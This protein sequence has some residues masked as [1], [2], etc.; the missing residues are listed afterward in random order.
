[1]T[2]FAASIEYD[3][4]L[5]LPKDK[6][7]LDFIKQKLSD[8][9]T[10]EQFEVIDKLFEIHRTSKGFDPVSFSKVRFKR[11]KSTAF[12]K[13]LAEINHKIPDILSTSEYKEHLNKQDQSRA[14]LEKLILIKSRIEIND[15]ENLEAAIRELKELFV[16]SKDYDIVVAFSKLLKP[17]L[18]AKKT[19]P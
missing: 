19:E 11:I 13:I 5:H 7:V 17:D 2:N 15:D 14:I 8:Y 16:V 18:V 6:E 3:N 9:Y 1:M 10:P 4:I 12:R